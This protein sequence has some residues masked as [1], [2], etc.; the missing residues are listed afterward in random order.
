[1]GLHLCY[2]LDVPRDTSVAEVVDR[3][4]RLYD[5]AVTLPFDEVGPFVQTTAGEALG[6]TTP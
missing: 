2:E 1:V 5:V 4:R 3:V 6:S